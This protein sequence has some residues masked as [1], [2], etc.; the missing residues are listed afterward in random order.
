MTEL[1]IPTEESPGGD[2]ITVSTA[3]TTKTFQAP[4][5]ATD[6]ARMGRSPR[7]H[8]RDFATIPTFPKDRAGIRAN[9]MTPQNPPTPPHRQYPDPDG[10]GKSASDL[11]DEWYT[12]LYGPDQHIFQPGP[13]QPIRSGN[14]LLPPNVHRRQPAADAPAR[15]PP[16]AEGT[17]PPVT[18]QVRFLAHNPDAW[19]TPSEWNRSCSVDGRCPAPM[20]SEVCS[21]DEDERITQMLGL[22]TMCP[23]DAARE[24]S[25]VSRRDRAHSDMLL[26]DM[27]KELDPTPQR[28]TSLL[29][30]P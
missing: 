26:V 14:V 1:T 5:E 15:H 28:N 22:M 24:G 12:A 18:R 29:H 20:N 17:V 13:D 7:E 6:I 23:T 25:P 10:D 2:P 8:E 11:I 30:Q 16:R 9:S 21:L 19:K 3:R 4:E 27:A